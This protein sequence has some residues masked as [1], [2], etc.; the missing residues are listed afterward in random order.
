MKSLF[1]TLL[2]PMKPPLRRNVRRKNCMWNASIINRR[3]RPI[4][5]HCSETHRMAGS[6]AENERILLGTVYCTLDRAYASGSTGNSLKVH[7]T[8]GS[9]NRRTN[10]TGHVNDTHYVPTWLSYVPQ[11]IPQPETLMRS[12]STYQPSRESVQAEGII[13]FHFI[14]A[15]PCLRTPDSP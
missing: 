5:K 3:T 1:P 2:F 8:N 13:Y 4:K 6:S 9:R 11:K 15:T 14:L 10:T 7:N 12:G